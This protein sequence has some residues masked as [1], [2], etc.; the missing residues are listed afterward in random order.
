M[1]KRKLIKSEPGLSGATRQSW[2][3]ANPR[4]LVRSIIERHPGLDRQRQFEIFLLEASEEVKINAMLYCFNN[5]CAS[6][7][8]QTKEKRD[9]A[10]QKRDAEVVAIKQ[11][12]QLLSLVM[13][14]GKRLADC[15]GSE[16]VQ[17]GGWALKVGERVGPN[18][19]VG[20]VLTEAQLRK[21]R[22][23]TLAAVA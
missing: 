18:R 8:K 22:P 2:R 15:T 5:T 4:V 10:K 7:Q 13:P 3:N 16:C 9:A 19:L 17:F 21:I 6:Y 14:N 20:D 12:I 11:R 1:T 23:V